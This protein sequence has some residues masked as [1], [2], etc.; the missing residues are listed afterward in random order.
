VTW[1]RRG[2]AV[3]C[4]LVLPLAAARAQTH[5]V[6]ADSPAG[7]PATIAFDPAQARASFEVYLRA[8]MRAIGRFDRVSGQMQGSAANGWRVLV[9]IDGTSL[10]F[11][12]PAWM[13][14]IS[15][16]E[17][18]LALDRHPDI[19]FA[20]V[21]FADVML[22]TG[23]ELHGELRLRGRPRAVVFE[24]LAAEC[25]RPGYDC[26]IAVRGR[27]SRHAFGMNTQR[28]MVRD[29]VD[30]RFRVRFLAPAQPDME[31]RP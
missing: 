5:P 18:F 2:A 30:F 29:E 21:P 9:V 13:G 14:R 27:I 16:S 31:S 15:R 17:P 10:Q 12:G 1:G 4:L 28:I 25:A 7:S 11:E 22:R 24:L 26:D 3:L 8:P 23:G 6:S 20:S 19:R